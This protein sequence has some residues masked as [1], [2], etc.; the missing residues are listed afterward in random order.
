M[1]R[2]GCPGKE[3]REEP[4][5]VIWCHVPDDASDADGAADDGVAHDA[6]SDADSAADDGVTDAGDA[7]DADDDRSHRLHPP[8]SSQ[9]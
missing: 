2:P 5:D 4:C 7:D 9:N 6:D 1:D 8:S 3:Y